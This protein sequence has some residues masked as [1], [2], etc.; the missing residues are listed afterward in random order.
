MKTRFLRCLL[1]CPSRSTRGD[2]LG[3]RLP[4]PQF[5]S[6]QSNRSSKI[7]L[8][9]TFARILEQ[10]ENNGGV[11]GLGKSERLTPLPVLA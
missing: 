9:Q 11:V 6:T 1:P 8:S 7:L 3:D 4:E 5:I 2:Y 10:L